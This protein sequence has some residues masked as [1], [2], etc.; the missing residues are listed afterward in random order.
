M[1]QLYL[2]QTNRNDRTQNKIIK[3]PHE[4]YRFLATPGVEVRNLAFASD[5]VVWL[6]WKLY[7]EG[8]VPNLPHT[9]EVI[10]AYV[11]VVARIHM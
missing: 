1:S 5:D 8:N 4:L 2:G 6:S 3:V 9:N 10:C 11:N 7:A